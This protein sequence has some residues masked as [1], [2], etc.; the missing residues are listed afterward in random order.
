MLTRLGRAAGSAQA[1]IRAGADALPRR[2]PRVLMY[3]FFGDPPGD[4]D[5]ERLFVSREG[6]VAQLDR[7]RRWGWRPLDLDGY[8]AALAGAPVPR[9]SFLLTIDDGHASVADVAAPVLAAAGVPSVLFA[10][11]ALLGDRARWSRFYPAEPLA[12]AEQLAA[13]PGLGMELGLHGL[14]H[15]RMAGLAAGALD[16]HVVGARHALEAATGVRA[17]AFAYPYGTHDAPAREAVA[18]AG[19]GVA[20]AVAREGGRFAVDRIFVRGD[21]PAPVFRWK[22]SG[23]YRWMSR[24]AGRVPRLR[25]AVRTAVTPLRRDPRFRGAGGRATERS[26]SPR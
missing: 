5:P 15:T 25:R 9:R 22:L 2:S 21:E 11:P 1:I 16:E 8:L 12:T 14:D 17:R 19:Y 3:H 10:C 13:L 6:L 20:F 26:E 18:A 23:A 4:G 7:L 24:V